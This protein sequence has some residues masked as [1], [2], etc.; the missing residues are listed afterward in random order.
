MRKILTNVAQHNFPTEIKIN[1]KKFFIKKTDSTFFLFDSTCAHQGG[2]VEMREDSFVCPIHL[3]KYDKDGNCLTNRSQKL[4]RYTLV[5]KDDCLYCEDDIFEGADIVTH[6]N[7][8]DVAL[9][10]DIK[11]HA[12]ACVEVVLENFSI[13]KDPWLDGPAF[14]GSWIQYPLPKVKI[15]HLSPHAI[16]ITHE[17]P[18]HFSVHS[19]QKFNK[20]I[21]LYFP[22]FPNGR[23]EKIVQKMGF[24]NI[25]PIRF[26]D[27][28]ALSS[29]IEIF[30]YEPVSLWNDS[31]CFLNFKRG[32]FT[33][34]NYNDAGINHSI[35]KYLPNEID[36]LCGQ[37]SPGA[38]GYPLCFRNYTTEQTRAY[39]ERSR[40]GCIDLIQKSIDF[41]N[42][43]K[44]L[45][46]ASFFMLW[47][48][49]HQKYRE[50]LLL[51]T[52]VDLKRYIPREYQRRMLYLMPGEEFSYKKGVS[53]RRFNEKELLALYKKENIE[54]NIRKSFDEEFFKSHHK[55][56]KKI[57]VQD[58]IVYFEKFNSVPEI[59]QCNN[60]EINFYVT[61]DY[62]NSEV[63]Y[64]FAIKIIDNHLEIFKELFLECHLKFYVPENIIAN[65]IENN[66]SWDEAHIGYWCEF[67]RY[68]EN[69]EASFWRL[70]QSPYYKIVGGG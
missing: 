62:T 16:I 47:H 32:A 7:Y 34:L 56:A 38:S 13:L 11:V 35:R 28:C 21:P 19:L 36:L 1:R 57:S 46:F 23:I 18:D 67:E 40:K 43:A 70:L 37:F 52:M 63:N 31:I 33:L 15:E 10:I 26:G 54:S 51:N 25:F 39:Y 65:I 58:T 48:P 20:D 24:K 6:S 66:L 61:K 60:L 2:E 50:N 53:T 44:F 12:H 17:H 27:R 69:Y 22:A 64:S 45:P 14:L 68:N 3:W 30:F 8:R 41:Y 49:Y 9:D 5:E 55:S 4:Q 42:S 59:S 29:D